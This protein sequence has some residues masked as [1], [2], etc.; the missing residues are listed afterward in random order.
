MEGNVAN[1]VA[2]Q[3]S[4]ASHPLIGR[5]VA[6]RFQIMSFIGDGRIAQVF[7]AQQEG[8]P[9]HVALKVVL[10][11]FTADPDVVG[12]FLFA[13]EKC[14]RLRHGGIVPTHAAGEDRDVLY[15]ATDLVLGENLRSAIDA[16]GPLVESEAL[17][18]AGDVC[19]S[20]EYAL[21][22]GVLHRGLRPTNVLLTRTPDAPE[23][24]IVKLCDFGMSDVVEALRGRDPYASPEKARG[25]ANDSR[26][27]VYGFGALLFELLSGRAYRRERP[28]EATEAVARERQQH[29]QKPAAVQGA[30]LALLEGT[31]QTNAGD[32]FSS[33]REVGAELCKLSGSSGDG[34]D[35]G[36]ISRLAFRSVA[37]DTWIDRAR[38]KHPTPPE[39]VR[40]PEGGGS[41]DPAHAL[42]GQT[43][44]DRF[45]VVSFMRSGG[46]AH[47]FYGTRVDESQ[48]IVI[49]VLHPRLSE[50]PGLV[51]RFAREARLAAQLK[52]PNIIEILHVGDLYIAME[53]LAGEDLASRLRQ[54]RRLPEAH[55]AQ[56]A[57][58]IA[59]ALAYA[60][61]RA[62]VHRDIK[63]AN[64]M[65]CARADGEQ[66]KLLDFGIAK[67]LENTRDRIVSGDLTLNRSALTSVGDLV[68]TPRYM[69]PE[70][71][72]A[73]TIDGRTDLYSLGVVLYELV[74]GQVPFDGETALQIVARHV[75]D[76]PRSPSKLLPD[77]SPELEQLILQ[78]LEKNPA[79]R[80]SSAE[81]VKSRL[82]RM[83]PS[84]GLSLASAT[85]RWLSRDEDA[86]S[87]E[88]DP[89]ESQ[90]FLP[91]E[92][93]QAVL[94]VALAKGSTPAAPIEQPEPPSASDDHAVRME[95]LTRLADGVADTLDD[96]LSAILGFSSLISN[97]L[98]LGDPL[99]DD[100]SQISRAAER[101]LAFR[102]Q[103]LAFSGRQPL[104]P[105][106][107]E[108]SAH[109]A[110]MEALIRRLVGDA[111]SLELH[112]PAEVGRVEVDPKQ[113]EQVVLNLVLNA[114]EATPNGGEIT[115]ETAN[116]IVDR[117]DVHLPR[118]AP[119]GD[120][121]LI[122]VSDTGC[123]MPPSVHARAFEPFFT[124][125]PS[126]QAA[127]L[128]L[129]V[130]FGVVR[131]SGGHVLLYTKEGHGTEAE[132]Y[133]PAT[134]AAPSEEQ[135]VPNSVRAESG[136]TLLLVE[137]EELTRAFLRTTLVRNGYR[138]LEASNADEAVL[139]SERHRGPLQLLI[140][141]AVS[142]RIDGGQLA[143]RLK[144]TRGSLAVVFLSS[145]TSDGA[146]GQSDY[147]DEGHW[148][149]KPVSPAA[150][151]L[152]VRKAL[153]R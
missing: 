35:E 146:A 14:K 114:R 13:A 66:V 133:L 39:I 28:S 97:A 131:Q 115:I 128:G 10:P 90:L 51:K 94:D 41:R 72:R 99:L 119:L 143:D 63:P 73:E 65:I 134:S 26:A 137:E 23:L 46:M 75:Q 138:V 93:V 151:L 78:L 79:D 18:I 116:V 50:E 7:C 34:V 68:G 5:I 135:H 17:R 127:G 76:E 98:R 74:T 11:A 69:S 42:I 140:A 109:I 103:L 3:K 95:S 54:R 70:Q 53:L 145:S 153:G 59:S 136:E 32:R 15:L 22:L 48:R 100:V 118:G 56:I 80:P 108:V 92:A 29:A 89:D 71:G 106:V 38:G 125:K 150:L 147:F 110:E 58:E 87:A 142:P 105:R 36:S 45:R 139:V 16:R 152:M 104:S 31:L 83:L 43:L 21:S 2:T 77:I 64:I 4:R 86:L 62:V 85:S 20:L 96:A 123:G 12:R 82:E 8:E 107:V 124:T 19:K 149:S 49:K 113:L 6:E 44:D 101:A 60:H 24:E 120:Y 144:Q 122:S 111:V 130:V 132:V 33:I 40:A 47:L 121:V 52:H 27:D 67:V 117:A 126:G 112:L 25:E 30:L 141:S 57:I 84:L 129:A 102:A 61:G 55:A 37:A 91:A 88:W 9:R 1:T 81:E 148:L